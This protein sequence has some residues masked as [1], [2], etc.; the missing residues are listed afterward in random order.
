MY[1][2]CVV[3]SSKIKLKDARNFLVPKHAVLWKDI[4]INLDLSVE[5]LNIIERDY[6]YQ[7]DCCRE[8]LTKWLQVDLNASLEKLNS[9]LKMA[10]P[11]GKC[12]K[13]MSSDIKPYFQGSYKGLFIQKAKL[14]G[15]CNQLKRFI[16]VAFINH[17]NNNVEYPE[18]EAVA[19]ILYQGEIYL[20][21]EQINMQILSQKYYDGY[22]KVGKISSDVFKLLNSLYALK[23]RDPFLLLIEGAPGM[24][25]SYISKEI[26]YQWAMDSFTKPEM[27]F[28]LCLHDNEA[29]KICSVVSFLEF[30]YPYGELEVLSKYLSNTKGKGVTVIIDGYDKFCSKLQNHKSV[31][32]FEQLISRIV[33]QLCKCDIIITSSRTASE[34]IYKVKNCT[35][36]ELIGFNEDFKQQYIQCAFN[37]NSKD[38]KDLMEYLSAHPT[39]NSLCYIPLCLA[40]VV[41]QFKRS[42]GMYDVALPS[43]RTEII[44]RLI[45][46]IL[47]DGLSN[48][49]ITELFK[50]LPKEEQLILAELS[51]IAF[52]VLQ[53][54][55][56]VF[57][58]KKLKGTFPCIS[59]VQSLLLYGFGFLNGLNHFEPLG[60]DNVF[61][62]FL[63]YSLRDYLAAFHVILLPK[64]KQMQMWNETCW[65]SMYL[66]CW[67]YY[68]KLSISFNAVKSSLLKRYETLG[69]TSNVLNNKIKCLYLVY[70][71]M[72]LP[73]DNIYQ[74][75]KSLV[76][77]NSVLDLS[78]CRLTGED[79][80]IFALFLSRHPLS[81]WSSLILS[82]C[83]IDDGK[84]AVLSSILYPLQRNLPIINKLNVAHNQISFI[85]EILN[86]STVFDVLQ[87]DISFNKIE[88][89]Q[90]TQILVSPTDII[91]SKLAQCN[92]WLI[93]SNQ[94]CFVFSMK[95]RDV[96]NKHWNNGTFTKLYVVRCLLDNA[97]V[98]KLL[99]SLKL[100]S[101][102]SSIFLFDTNITGKDFL[103]LINFL[104]V[105]PHVNSISV[106]E[107][108]LSDETAYDIHADIVNYQRESHV[109]LISEGTIQAQSTTNQ[110]ILQALLYNPSISHIQLT[111]CHLTP[112]IMGRIA[113]ILNESLVPWKM[114]GLSG[115]RI[116][117]AA[118]TAFCNMLETS[119]KV[120]V[121]NLSGNQLSSA[122]LLAETSVK[123]DV[124]NLSGNQ[125]SSES[126]LAELVCCLNPETVD[127]SGNEFSTNDDY[128]PVALVIA[129][130]LFTFKEQLSLTFSTDSGFIKFCQIKFSCSSI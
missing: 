29:N 116:D 126:L 19:N 55:K 98:N 24:G 10:T 35:R 88:D 65:K 124:V 118:L 49:H 130:N 43:Y 105:K 37:G 69:L 129:Q 38:M 117:N 115:C 121:V 73:N 48:K 51:K 94:S 45:C 120:D 62:S 66:N 106:F 76:I 18:I 34:I 36:I 86:I 27:L 81:Q 95:Q 127:I 50:K 47:H 4:G 9:A 46:I 58:L 112:K 64:E 20:S 2:I 14:Y 72:E 93:N 79:L 42:R 114:L 80:D 11:A 44:N 5:A 32:F 113:I 53:E 107:K 68:C 78:N 123:V 85:E 122:S 12:L 54:D 74:Q 26:A 33:P 40:T 87:L 28:Y 3:P 91:S 119:V 15:Y 99:N 101:H 102:L 7:E 22:F 71:L 92:L 23:H 77:K 52:C 31:L 25:K 96:I 21:D 103:K 57:E 60:I 8:M 128:L 90:V 125:L 100:Q 41:S 39:L 56:V 111:Q 82:S 16:N 84:C 109:L 59:K 75:V 89:E 30:V 108:S 17:K 67:A 13:H 61:F 70:C 63:H 97:A 83:S 104:K 1:V 6:R 110:Q